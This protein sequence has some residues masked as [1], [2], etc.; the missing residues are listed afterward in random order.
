MT[1]EELLKAVVETLKGPCGVTLEVERDS[2]LV[3]DLKLDSMGLLALAV[4]LE[5]KFRVRLGDPPEGPPAKV[6]DV[7]D[8]LGQ[9]LENKR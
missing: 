1:E 9:A 5:N 7:V 8:L 6:C 2:R 4:G 3:E